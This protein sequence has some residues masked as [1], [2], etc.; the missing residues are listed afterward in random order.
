MK[1][2]ASRSAAGPTSDGCRLDADGAI[3]MSGFVG[4]RCARVEAD[5]SVSCE[6]V[7]D[8]RVVA[9]MLGG[10]DGRTL[11][12]FVSLGSHPDEVADEGLTTVVAFDTDSPRA[13]HP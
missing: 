10:D 1:R 3:S 6:I 7:L 13:G 8:G 2:P 9:S 5:G 4:K 11:Y 12:G